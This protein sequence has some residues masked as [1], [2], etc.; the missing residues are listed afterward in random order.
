MIRHSRPGDEPGLQAL[1]QI[2]FGDSSE[3]IEAFFSALYR[4]GQ[5]L[6]WTEGD[7]IVSA[8]YLLD[9]GSLPLPG[10]ANEQRQAP[11]RVSYSYALATLPNFRGRGIG[12]Q[13]VQSA[14]VRSFET[15]F[16]CNVICPAE[17]ALFPYYARLGYDAVLPIAQGEILRSMVDNSVSII[18]IM[19]INPAV[20]FLIRSALLPS[21]SVT[22]PA[23]YLQFVTR[24]C[25]TSGGGLYRLKVDGQIGCAAV[26]R[27][28]TE[29]FISEILPASLAEQ[30]ARR[31]LEHFGAES[32]RFRTV[33]GL[34]VP[35]Q[36]PFVLVAQPPDRP[37]PI[38]DGYFP[39]VLD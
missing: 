29:L 36:R 4:P 8:I 12:T 17:E 2:A 13:V 10:G 16:D 1:W 20:Y 11:L 25:L 23:D 31:L 38:L 21:Q 30:G 27:R 15:G 28:G 19:S 22:Y 9:A 5:A 6:L 32:V 35:P 34:D 3:A 24:S 7:Q 37:L 18:N 14:I 39:F 33:P 26:E